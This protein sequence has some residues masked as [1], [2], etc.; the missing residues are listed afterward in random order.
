MKLTP[1]LIIVES[2]NP[3]W[4]IFSLQISLGGQQAGSANP[5]IVS[6]KPSVPTAMLGKVDW[7][8]REGCERLWGPLLGMFSKV[9]SFEQFFQILAA[10]I[11]VV[12]T[13][14]KGH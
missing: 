8:R 10:D 1:S 14:K 6:L 13:R 4:I 3:Q 5:A 11:P 9:G 2:G 7:R 12:H